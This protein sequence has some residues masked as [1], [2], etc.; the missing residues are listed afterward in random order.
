MTIEVTLGNIEKLLAQIANNTTPIKPVDVQTPVAAVVTP[1]KPARAKAEKPAA[2]APTPAPAVVAPVVEEEDD[3]LAEDAA[4][5]VA[6]TKDDVRASFVKLQNGRPDGKNQVYAV[7]KQFGASSL[8]TL[9]VDKYGETV[10]AVNA[11]LA[12]K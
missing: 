2:P 4:P 10:A 3:F 1:I 6:L 8:G 9:A 12:T 7:L 5:A 11:L